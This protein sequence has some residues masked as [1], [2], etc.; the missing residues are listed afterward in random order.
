M[1]DTN[2]I[3]E[4]REQTD[5]SFKEIKKALEEANG[6]KIK[7]LELLKTRGTALAG[8]KADRST[9]EGI[10]EAYIHGNGKIGV[11]LQLFCE[12]DFVGKNPAFKNLAHEIAM[13]IAAMNPENTEALLSQ[14]FIKDPSRIVQDIINDGVAKLG[15]NIKV[16]S[17][18]RLVL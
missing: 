8:K 12:T 4:I 7:A 2:A 16:G 9:A 3:K 5:L 15:E 1:A 6:D 17:F 10:I 13:H 14:E 18:T 11:L